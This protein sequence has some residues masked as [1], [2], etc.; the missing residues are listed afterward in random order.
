MYVLQGAVPLQVAKQKGYASTAK[1]L[2]SH[3]GQSSR[4]LVSCPSHAACLLKA[5]M[6]LLSM[7]PAAGQP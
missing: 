6:A 3:Q 4:G 7:S 2:M 5:F 1:V